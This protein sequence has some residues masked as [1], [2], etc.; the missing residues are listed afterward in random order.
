[1]PITK[2]L[3]MIKKNL[4]CLI[5]GKVQGV[6]FRDWTAKKAFRYDLKGWVKN[7]INKEVELEV[8]GIESNLNLFLKELFMGPTL[9][10]VFKVDYKFVNFRKLE[11]F[12]IL[13]K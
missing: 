7:C 11:K 2:I 9:A 8:S 4:H 3:M 6:G 13:A 10:E 5:Y 12:R 1:M